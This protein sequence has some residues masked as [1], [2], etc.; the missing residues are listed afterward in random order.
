MSNRQ[1]VERALE[2]F[3][4]PARRAE[5]FQ[6]YSEDVV[7][8]G[9]EG[10]E[11]GL[12]SVKKFYT[13]FWAAFPDAALAAEDFVEQDDSVVVRYVISGT[14]QQT[15]MGVAATGQKIRL[16]GISFLRFSNGRCFERWT[17]SDS[18]V[19]LIQIGG[20]PLE[21]HN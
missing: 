12:E 19:L 11:P 21:K 18:L 9:Y 7:L 8:H 2:R 15:F 16:P 17:A 14:Q 4:D 13:A 6:L 10:V 3:S 20:F 5:Y 1:I